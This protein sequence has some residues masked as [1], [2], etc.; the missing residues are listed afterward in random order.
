MVTLRFILVCI[1]LRFCPLPHR[2]LLVLSPQPVVI[3][4]SNWKNEKSYCESWFS[5]GIT[6]HNSE[7][8][9]MGFIHCI[10]R[11]NQIVK[12]SSKNM[13]QLTI[14]TEESG[15]LM[16]DMVF[17]L[18]HSNCSIFQHRFESIFCA[19]ICQKKLRKLGPA[20]E[21]NLQEL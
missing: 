14:K 5:F 21:Q 10:S 4:V 3:K 8:R 1:F 15:S 6:L 20:M 2:L 11:S 9:V 16:K 7:V 12:S 18:F 13:Y 17:I 19:A